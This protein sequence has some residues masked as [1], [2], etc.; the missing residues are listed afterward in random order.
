VNFDIVV[1]L[2]VKKNYGKKKSKWCQMGNHIM[3]GTKPPTLNIVWLVIIVFLTVNNSVFLKNFSSISE[4]HKR[5][6]N[7]PKKKADRI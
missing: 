5:V 6:R 4:P 1:L 3:S 7:I 2:F